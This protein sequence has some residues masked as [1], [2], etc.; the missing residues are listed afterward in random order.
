MK[1]L[2]L[3]FFPILLLSLMSC[4]EN[5]NNI[6]MPL[7]D[8][9]AGLSKVTTDIDS[10]AITSNITSTL[11]NNDAI[12]IVGIIDHQQNASSVNLL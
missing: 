11:E 4:N 7:F 3:F 12:S 8:D 6:D 9:V 5:D 2:Y 1:T 10:E